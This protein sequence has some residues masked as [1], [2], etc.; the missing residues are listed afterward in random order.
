MLKNLALS[1]RRK[2]KHFMCLRCDDLG[3]ECTPVENLPILLHLQYKV[4]KK[5]IL[6]YDIHTMYSCLIDPK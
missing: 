1:E 5:N 6:E 3:N 2:N 4:H